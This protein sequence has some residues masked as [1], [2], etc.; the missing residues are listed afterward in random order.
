MYFNKIGK[1]ILG[2]FLLFQ[3][4]TYASHKVYVLHGFGGT[5]LQMD[6]I[7]QALQKDGYLTENYTY[8][9]F[10]EDL[11]SLGVDL[12]RKVSQEHFDSVSFVT[13]SMGGLVVRSMYQY[14]DKMTTFPFV[15]RIVMLAPPNK[16]SELAE[17][18]FVPFVKKALGPNLNYMKTLPDSYV[19]KLPIPSAELG[20]IAG[21]RGQKPWYN[22]LLMEDNDGTVGLSS[23]YLG[24]ERDVV[25]IQATHSTMPLR[26]SVVKLVLRFMKMGNF[27]NK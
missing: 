25:I 7:Y 11:D 14:K 4:A 8:P 10:K 16:G 1:I 20:I 12:C 19:F 24:G 17:I 9:S 26:P 5:K 2:V 3:S 22:P 15:F 23:V 6:K 13:H 27:K 18:P 21:A